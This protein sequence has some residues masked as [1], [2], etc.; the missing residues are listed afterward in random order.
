MRYYAYTVYRDGQPVYDTWRNC[1][2]FTNKRKA[3]KA[4]R[5][6]AKADPNRGWELRTERLTVVKETP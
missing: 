5:H 6:W 3:E 2:P 1:Q 4:L